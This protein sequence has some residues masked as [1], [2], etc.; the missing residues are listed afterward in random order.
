M[1]RRQKK[2][3]PREYSPAQQKI[4]ALNALIER[5]QMEDGIYQARMKSLQEKERRHVALATALLILKFHQ[6]ITTEEVANQLGVIGV[7]ML[8][9]VMTR[10]SYLSDPVFETVCS[11]TGARLVEV[12]LAHR[13]PADQIRKGTYLNE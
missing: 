7:E 5:I 6:G 4:M 12:G 1:V 13:N 11:A 10:R 8:R 9:K 2:D 3:K